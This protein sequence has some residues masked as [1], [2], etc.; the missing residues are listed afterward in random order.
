MSG[1][2]QL[3]RGRLALGATVLI[4]STPPV[5]QYWLA[6]SF[7]PWTQNFYRYAA[8]FLAML[9]FLLWRLG[10]DRVLWRR[11]EWRGCAIASVPNAV[12]QIAQTV[13]VVFLLPGIYALA[14]RISVIMTAVLAV[15]FF[16]DERWITQ[17]GRFIA[18]TICGL[19]GLAG[20]VWPVGMAVSPGWGTGFSLALLAA[21]GWSFYAILVKKHTASVGPTI[22][23]GVIGFFTVALMW[24]LMLIF[25]EPSLLSGA[26]AWTLSV[27]F[28]SG[29]IS[30]GI[31]HWLYYIGIRD[32]GAASA[33]SALLLCP[34]GTMMISSALMGE[35]FRLE[36]IVAGAVLLGG[37]FL[38]L[39]AR[40][41][42][43]E[44]P[45]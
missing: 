4:W 30:I 17:S 32:L 8:G 14:G 18:G 28:G 16:A 3:W 6:K 21:A 29:V 25:G 44:E 42:V 36:Q 27:L 1:D 9:P 38:A 39:T 19:M 35:T 10:R 15:V 22:G 33:Q 24:P 45:A 34:L 40:P 13:A 23:F 2:R 20:L 31:G 26:D 11:I 12:H 5:F 37:A 41:P 43:I 7:D